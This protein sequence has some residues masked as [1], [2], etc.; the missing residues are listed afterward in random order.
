MIESN[1]V[2]FT[3]EGGKEAEICEATSVENS[4][5]GT[6]IRI[7]RFAY[8]VVGGIKCYGNRPVCFASV[9]NFIAEESYVLVI[10]ATE[11][12]ISNV[13]L[14]ER[15]LAKE[16]SRKLRV[17]R[18]NEDSDE[19]TCYVWTIAKKIADFILCHS[20]PLFITA[21]NSTPAY[22]IV[23]LIGI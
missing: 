10:P 16:L 8:A 2:R 11:R 5:Y 21:P 20:L 13:L 3:L 14:L 22:F 23:L 12:V 19:L 18:L 6:R 1:C 4:G 7:G 9:Q 15:K 17:S